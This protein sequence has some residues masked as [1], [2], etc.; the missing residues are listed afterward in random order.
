MRG[1]IF[2]DFEEGFEHVCASSACIPKPEEKVEGGRRCRT[3]NDI[4]KRIDETAGFVHFVQARNLDEP[5]DIVRDEL[6][7]DDPFGEFVPFFLVPA[8]TFSTI[9]GNIVIGSKV[10]GPRS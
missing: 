4:L 8:H 2:C 6:V 7:M 5:S 3:P 10:R 9:S 1:W